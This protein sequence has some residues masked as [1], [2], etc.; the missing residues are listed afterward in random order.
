MTGSI[1]SV[2][3]AKAARDALKAQI[4]EERTFQAAVR[5]S[6]RTLEQKNAALDKSR[7]RTRALTAAIRELT[8]AEQQAGVASRVLAGGSRILS[9]AVTG[10]GTAISLSLIHI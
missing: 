9:V 6:N 1:G 8:A 4:A 10:L 2:A 5:V 3:E 7:G